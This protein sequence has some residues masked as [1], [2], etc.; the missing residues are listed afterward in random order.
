LFSDVRLNMAKTAKKKRKPKSTS[1]G[2]RGFEFGGGYLDAVCIDGHLWDLD[3]CE[4]PGG[5][6]YHG[7]NIGCPKCNPDD[8]R[9]QMKCSKAEVNR[10]V[11][12]AFGPTPWIPSDGPKKRKQT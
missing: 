3:S 10:R 9:E 12:R 2:Y 6:L 11:K 8:Y 4:V 7:G 1:C 5:P